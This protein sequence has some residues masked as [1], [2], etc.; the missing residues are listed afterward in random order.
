[1]PNLRTGQAFVETIGF[2]LLLA[3]III[4]AVIPTP[5][6]T[7]FIV[8]LGIIIFFISFVRTDIALF[9]LIFSMLLSPEFQAGR[10][11]GRAVV[12]RA[13]DIYI[14]VIFL[15]WLAKMAVNKE[16]GLLRSGPLNTPIIL[17]MAV[18]LIATLVGVIFH[19]VRFREAILYFLKYF[20]YFLLYFLVSNNLK[21]KKEA[22]FYVFAM[23]AVACA[24][25]IYAWQQHFSG[26]QRVTAPF[27]G[28]GGEANTLGGYL[29]VML[30]MMVSFLLNS[31]SLA[32]RTVMAVLLCFAVP[33]FFFTLS[34]SSWFSFL[35]ALLVFF[36]LTPRG[37]AAILVLLLLAVLL[38]PVILPTFVKK[39]VSETFIGSRQYQFMGQTVTLDES[40]TA[41]IDTWKYGIER[42]AGAPILGYGVSSAGAVL[43]NQYVRILVETGLLGFSA[44]IF[45]LGSLFG[46]AVRAFNALADDE[47]S[48]C[49]IVAFMAGFAGL[50]VHAFGAATF[51][52]VRIMEPFWFLA[53]IIVSLSE[54]ESGTGGQVTEVAQ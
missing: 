3:A 34:R 43:D 52:L 35:P 6:H 7:A 51:I 1:M 50:L 53:A 40:S 44:F 26:V 29:I 22:R 16:L 46:S 42:W 9:L 11:T 54:L 24:V 20:E 25:S 38:S 19:S 12:I 21:N 41:R 17:Y 30:L 45:L 36:F 10:V 13:D 2:F 18:C 15:G 23:L 14:L 8:I 27:E 47:F 31:T 28:Q 39:R 4:L 48:R 32:L 5:Y 49:L 37:K 33:A